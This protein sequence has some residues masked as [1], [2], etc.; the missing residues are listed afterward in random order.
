M[1]GTG[2]ASRQVYLGNNLCGIYWNNDR[3]YMICTRLVL[4]VYRHCL[5]TASAKTLKVKDVVRARF[6]FEHFDWKYPFIVPEDL[7][8]SVIVGAYFMS[9]TDLVIDLQAQQFSFMF[10][11]EAKLLMW[12][13]MKDKGCREG[14]RLW[15][16]SFPVGRWIRG[17][18]PVREFTGEK[19]AVIRHVIHYWM[20]LTKS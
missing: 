12:V 6:Q 20:S 1:T 7:P 14:M 5:N 10:R 3:P 9:K 17:K 2:R 18:Q 8:L 19:Q 4:Q 13:Q 11:T 15:R 16:P